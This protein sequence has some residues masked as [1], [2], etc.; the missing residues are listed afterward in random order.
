V[1][2]DE[3]AAAGKEAAE[4]DVV[5]RITEEATVKSAAEEA[6]ATR[7]AEG[8][9]TE[10]A[11][12]KASAAEAI[13]AAG[14]S[15]AP[16]QTPSAAGPRGLWLQVAPPHRPNVPTWVFGNLSLSSFLS[17]FGLILLL[18]FFA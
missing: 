11:A 16:G 2:F 1:V 12:V 8:R 7:V 15:P 10:E 3:A 5:R 9:A 6:A 14:G 4:E 13:G 17:P 18:P